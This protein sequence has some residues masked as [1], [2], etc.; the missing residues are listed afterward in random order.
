MATS[1]KKF[2][3]FN[4]KLNPNTFKEAAVLYQKTKRVAGSVRGIT[5]VMCLPYPFFGALGAKHKKSKVCMIGTQNVYFEEK[6]AF[7]GEV[8]ASQIKSLN[9]SH[10]IVG[11]SERRAMGETD[12]VVNKKVHAVLGTGMTPIICIGESERDDHGGYLE[13]LKGQLQAALL[14][15]EHTQLKHIIVAY[16]PIWAIGK[17]EDEAMQPH[18]IH[19][20]VIF[21]EKTIRE[22]YG[23]SGSGHVPVLYGGSVGPDNAKTIVKEGEVDGLLIGHKSLDIEAVK[24]ILKTV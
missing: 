24:A 11:H 15:V 7:T 2:I 9:G 20:I 3:V 8:S 19:Q 4:W 21:I 23:S 16:E 1:K 13:F 18:D 17:S 5:T 10:V 12:E 6:G 22:L 14:H